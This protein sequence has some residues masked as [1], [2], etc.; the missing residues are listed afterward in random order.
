MKFK[1]RNEVAEDTEV[2]CDTVLIELPVN[3]DDEDIPYDFP[4]REHDVL[5]LEVLIADGKIVDWPA[6]WGAVR[7]VMKV[8]DEGTY[9][10]FD[11][12]LPVAAIEQWYV[13][14]G[15][16]PGEYGDYVEFNINELGYITNWPKSP[17]VSEFFK[18]K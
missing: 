10:L 16:I 17:D 6:D 4:F 8:V 5:T 2:Q 13:P 12:G 11:Q 14:H 7:V 1:A 15:L 9:T 18:K 3:Y